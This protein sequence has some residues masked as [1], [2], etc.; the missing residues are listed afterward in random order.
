M[1]ALPEQLSGQLSGQ[2]PEQPSAPA[3]GLGELQA[4][5]QAELP[6]LL[7]GAPYT[8]YAQRPLPAAQEEPEVRV[9]TAP[10]LLQL[11]MVERAEA[12]WER[13]REPSEEEWLGI[14]RRA[15]EA[16]AR[17]L[18]DTSGLEDR[19]GGCVL[20]P[21]AKRAS[22]TS[23]LP[24]QR[25]LRSWRTLTDTLLNLEGCLREQAPGRSLE[26]YRTG[27]TGASWR[28][29]PAGRTVAVR[30]PGNSPTINVTWLQALAARRPVLLNAP[31]EDPF[32]AA[33]FALALQE[34]G[35]PAG[36]LS[37]AY[38]DTPL[39]WQRADQVVWP[40][41]PPAELLRRGAAL[42]TY[43]QG[44]SKVILGP[45]PRPKDFWHRLA[46][47]VVQGCGRLCTNASSLVVASEDFGDAAAAGLELAG[48][49]QRY[50]VLP[51]EDPAA[52]VPAFPDP[53]RRAAV[54]AMIEG[55]LARGARDLSHEAGAGPLG[56]EIDGLAF[57]RP[58]VILL[59]AGDPLFGAELPFPFVTVTAATPAQIPALCRGSLITAP[60]GCD[61]D[62]AQVLALE[63]TV[64][65]V[66]AD[67]DFDHGYRP[68]EPHEGF[69][70]D[71]LF[72][73]K[74]VLAASAGPRGVE[75]R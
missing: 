8:T 24:H 38:G 67:E 68:D 58:T 59:E 49:L 61:E 50:P 12:C 18:E 39:F 72:H 2:L 65:K 36:A 27:A 69:L 22:R 9:A 10:R 13:L 33:L 64:D 66:F 23:G 46:R 28:W 42:R 15:G 4:L 52:I 1:T 57:L 32:T 71:F 60:V 70:A 63:P 34:A 51:L 40:G 54:A 45:G 48:A 73:K 56:Q 75:Q 30:I 41:D 21:V 35:L 7:A 55:A 44:R 74:S 47:M 62:L 20:E 3:S 14:F 43:H 37:L 16:L 31:D 53:Q 11:R 26:A 29:L 5:L 19:N 6:A 25:I 17:R